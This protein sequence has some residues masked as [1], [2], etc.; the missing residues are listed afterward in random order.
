MRAT[1]IF[2]MN[3]I[4]NSKTLNW[5]HYIR[6]SDCLDPKSYQSNLGRKCFVCS[7]KN[8]IWACEAMLIVYDGDDDN[9]AERVI[10]QTCG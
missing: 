8:I 9:S 10:I 3:Y 7:N 4:Y 1:E 6:H 2:C 5:C